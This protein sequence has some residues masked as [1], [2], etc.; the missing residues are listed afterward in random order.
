[1]NQEYADQ[2]Y[3][4]ADA[5]LDGYRNGWGEPILWHLA[6]RRHTDAML[7]LAIRIS[8]GKV[9]DPFSRSGLGRKAFRLGS[10]RAAQH[11]AM[12]CFNKGNLAGYRIWLHRAA[13]GGDGEAAAE[14]RRFETRLPHAAARRLKRIRP[15][16]VSD[17]LWTA[18][19][20]ASKPTKWYPPDPFRSR[21]EQ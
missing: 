14:L 20:H 15:Y 9:F 3:K 6:L 17:G 10:K 1:M 21:T 16:R 2:L 7:A 4:R 11:L 12:N 8:D 13:H 19:R 18:N 5:I